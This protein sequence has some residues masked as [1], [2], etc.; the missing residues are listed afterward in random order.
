M[1]CKQR[2]GGGR[3][4]AARVKFGEKIHNSLEKTNFMSDEWVG[5]WKNF[6]EKEKVNYV[7]QKRAVTSKTCYWLDIIGHKVCVL[8]IL[9]PK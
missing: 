2:Y 4:S 3:L 9:S 6:W 7:K 5:L 1:T 8:L